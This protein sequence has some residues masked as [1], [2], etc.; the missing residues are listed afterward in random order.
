MKLY[1]KLDHVATLRQ[2]GGGKE[3]EPV[4]AAALAELEGIGGI[5]IHLHADRGNVKLRDV[6]VLKETLRVPL[7]LELAPLVKNRQHALDLRPDTLTLVQEPRDV[8]TDRWPV[9]VEDRDQ[10]AAFVK[11]VHEGGLN[12]AVLVRPQVEAIRLVHKLGVST[13]MLDSTAYALTKTPAENDAA[14]EQLADGVRLG[15]KLGMEV[16]VGGGLD[17]H[18]LARVA[19]LPVSAVHVGYALVARA[20][21]VGVSRAASQMRELIE[22]AP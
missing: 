15:Q 20:L 11:S 9:S 6:Q 3:P 16:H 13:L 12:T 8:H 10:L 5:T 7:N 2:A 14:F 17:Y 21:L 4:V 1:F 18:N 22:K 19:S